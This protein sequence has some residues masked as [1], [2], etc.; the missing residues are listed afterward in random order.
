MW[1][2]AENYLCLLAFFTA[3]FAWLTNAELLN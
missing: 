1:A 3:K 2:K